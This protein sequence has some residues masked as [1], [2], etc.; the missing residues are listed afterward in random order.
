MSL[1]ILEERIS[2]NSE[3]I[4]SNNS[5]NV[6]GSLK[7]KQNMLKDELEYNKNEIIEVF[8]EINQIE[9]KE[10]KVS[11]KDKKNLVT[12]IKVESY[13][14]YNAPIEIKGANSKKREDSITCRNKNKKKDLKKKKKKKD[15]E[16]EEKY[17]DKD[18]GTGKSCV[19]F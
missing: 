19:I 12:I 11:F 8:N 14:K 13:K 7:E 18:E 5:Q 6:T 9:K 15:E 17:Y 10:K 16:N 1:L 2:P 4:E 3:F